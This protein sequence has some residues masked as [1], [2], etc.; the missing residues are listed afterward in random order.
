MSEWGEKVCRFREE[1]MYLMQ[2]D[3]MNDVLYE[4]N[5]KKCVD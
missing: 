5:I 3:I 4:R 2:R 1:K